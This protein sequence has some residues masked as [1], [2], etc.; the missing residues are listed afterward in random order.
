MDLRIQALALAM[1]MGVTAS[2]EGQSLVIVSEEAFSESAVYLLL[3][4]DVRPW[5]TTIVPESSAEKIFYKW[6]IMFRGDGP[7]SP[8]VSYVLSPAITPPVNLWEIVNRGTPN[9]GHPM[10]IDFEIPAKR[11]GFVLKGKPETPIVVSAFASSGKLL[12]TATGSQLSGW[13]GLESTGAEGISK[14]VIDYGESSREE[15]IDDLVVDFV[16]GPPVFEVYIPQVGDGLATVDGQSVSLGTVLRISNLQEEYTPEN[17]ARIG[18]VVDFFENDGAPLFLQLG[19]TTASS[20]VLL[21]LDAGETAVIETKRSSSEAVSGYARIRA[22]GPVGATAEFTVRDEEGKIVTEAG[23]AAVTPVLR[24]LGGVVSD[25]SGSIDT[26]VALVNS[27]ENEA[28]SIRIGL[29]GSGFNQTADVDVEPGHHVA[30][31]LRELFPTLP[32]TFN[33]TLSVSS[34]V[35]IAAITLRTRNGLPLSSLQLDSLE[36]AKTP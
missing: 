19:G 28:S 5:D 27:S 4:W 9:A 24:S 15:E 17:R 8:E 31:F 6:G 10:I 20:S 35:P 26:G 33:G 1:V 3:P 34:G 30:M 23:I 32:A 18:A 7:T 25:S 16:S 12:G 2:L 22:E 14:L 13:K 29:S 21:S 36:L 11:V